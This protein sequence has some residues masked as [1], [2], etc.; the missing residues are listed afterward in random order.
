LLLAILLVDII[1]TVVAV[2]TI[3][4]SGIITQSE[5]TFTHASG[6]NSFN[7]YPRFTAD[8]NGDGF[9][10]LVGFGGSFVYV[11]LSN[12]AGFDATSQWLSTYFTVTGGYTNQNL[13][14]RALGDV[15]G[16]GKADLVAFGS[17]NIKVCLSSGSS[18]LSQSVWHTGGLVT[19]SG[20]ST[21]SLY[22]R[23]I[24]DVNGDGKG[25]AVGFGADGI[26]VA[27]SGGS[28]FGT[29]SWWSTDFGSNDGYSTYNAYPRAMGDV[30]G[31]GLADVV[32]FAS[33]NLY[34]A[35]SNGAGFESAESWST[36]FTYSS[37]WTSFES[38]PRLVA[39][40][41]G[42]G[43]ADIIGFDSATETTH[44]LYSNGTHFVDAQTF[45]PSG[46]ANSSTYAS[47]DVTPRF[48]GDVN[49]DGL[50]DIVGNAKPGIR[51]M[52]SYF[53]PTASP[54]PSPSQTP[55]P[56]PT[57]VPTQPPIPSPTI[58]PSQVPRSSSPSPIPAPAP[59]SAPTIFPSQVPSSSPS[60]I[61]APAPTSAPTIFPSQVPSSS[62]SPIPAPAPTSAPTI[63]PSQVPS[64]SPSPILPA[65]APTSA[66]TIFPSQVP[67]S[68]PSPLPA[69]APTSSPTIFPSESPSQV[70]SSSPSPIPA[71]APTTVPTLV[72][73][74]MPLITST[75][76][77]TVP[78]SFV[79]SS[80][81]TS[82]PTHFP[83]A[84]PTTYYR[85]NVSYYPLIDK[86]TTHSYTYSHF[87][88][89][90]FS[91]CSS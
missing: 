35:L 72:P 49:G 12:G 25:D 38:Y 43:Y 22:P 80:A 17:S 20:W 18:F 5:T 89:I 65:P 61:P 64:S 19:S 28:S 66:P 59:T 55:I 37:G 36:S 90:I 54:T 71:P 67:S 34:V 13:Y 24:A 50:M 9:D 32:A 2:Q 82:T 83:S 44:I 30:N 58:F 88:F 33:G 8:V 26:E 10:D 84:R 11:S 86:N 63:F 47:F 3:V 53:I 23:F 85:S 57:Q 87:R 40:L 75:Q 68:S 4:D 70:P 76:Q 56:P 7:T 39:D 79:L 14:P 73:T 41:N 69:P 31:D 62:P 78:P 46:F 42:D 91:S 45:S 52:L 77:P 51:H 48:M 6:W 21:S 1:T 74:S 29:L 27:L 81:P 16:D 15:N 60:P